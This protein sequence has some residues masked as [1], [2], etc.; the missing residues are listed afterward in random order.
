[1]NITLNFITLSIFAYILN[2]MGLIILKKALNLH[3]NIKT[4][5]FMK[6]WQFIIGILIELSALFLLTYSLFYI[7]LS[8]Q[9]PLSILTNIT[10]I[11]LAIIFLDEKVTERKIL[12]ILLSITGIF[13]IIVPITMFSLCYL[14]ILLGIFSL[15]FYL[16]ENSHIIK[17]KLNHLIIRLGFKKEK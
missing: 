3:P 5:R 11:F 8:I 2:G 9:F 7:D 12:V 15:F 14:F 10:V 6:T 4:F 16:L 1:M 13:L 17:I